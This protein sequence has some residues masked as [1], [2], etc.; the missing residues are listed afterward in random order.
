MME[1]FALKDRHALKA[2]AKVREA[3]TPTAT[4][5]LMR[6]TTAHTYPT[7]ISLTRMVMESA[8]PATIVCLLPTPTRATQM[9]T[10]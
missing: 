8:T 2:A 9:P 10:E 5:C 6:A 4:V 3:R 1:T 7:L